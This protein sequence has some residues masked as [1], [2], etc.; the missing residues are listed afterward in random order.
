[1]LRLAALLVLVVGDV[2][3]GAPCAGLG[4]DAIRV[5]MAEALGLPA[6]IWK[7]RGENAARACGV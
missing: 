2:V 4:D 7:E 5:G 6:D 1:M 3:I